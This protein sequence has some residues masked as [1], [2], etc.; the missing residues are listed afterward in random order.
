MRRVWTVRGDGR[1]AARELAFQSA[2][3]SGRLA[4]RTPMPPHAGARATSR[5]IVRRA[6]R[7]DMASGLRAVP[8]R[9]ARRYRGGAGCQAEEVTKLIRQAASHPIS[10]QINISGTNR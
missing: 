2:N 3:R 4:E 1:S 8:A 10:E 7:R 9:E 5:A 6:K